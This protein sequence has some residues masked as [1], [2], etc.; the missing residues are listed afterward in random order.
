MFLINEAKSHNASPFA[1]QTVTVGK[2]KKK[3]YKYETYV[4]NIHTYN[5][6]FIFH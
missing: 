2:E 6:S 4:L 5:T 3:K 1:Q